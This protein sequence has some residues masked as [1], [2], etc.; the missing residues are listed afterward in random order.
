M[1]VAARLLPPL[2]LVLLLAP[3]A[4]GAPLTGGASAEAA[5]GGQADPRRV[6]AI[7]YGTPAQQR[8]VARLFRV[9]PG[10]VTEGARP[11]V[12]VR[13]DERGVKRVSARV[14]VLAAGSGR[15]AARFSLGAVRTGRV[16]RVRWPASKRLG[17]GAYL[18]RLHVKD[19]FGATL[20]RAAAATGKAHLEVRPRPRPEKPQPEPPAQPTAPAPAR[21]NSFPVAGSGWSFGGDGGRFG[22]DRGGRR[23][24]GQDIAAPEGTPV[25]SPL[26]GTVS[27]VDYQ[28]RGAGHYVGLTADDGR[29]L[30][31]AHLQTGSIPVRVGDRV[32]AGAALGRVGTTGSSS[33]PHLHFEIWIGGWR[34]QGGR[35]VDPL[36]Q[37]REWAAARR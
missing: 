33:G 27:F 14:V 17:P 9:T 2:L 20:A 7:A 24:E 4:S 22:A 32:A 21:G 28:A 11:T 15:V 16:A 29:F 25:V 1:R 12:Q 19:P 36:P 37:L 10:R 13:I 5:R 23:H 6:G 30:F 31:F 34:H 3:P 35:P 26:A 8:P 18:V